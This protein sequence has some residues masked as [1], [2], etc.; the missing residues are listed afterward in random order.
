MLCKRPPAVHIVFNMVDRF[1]FNKNL[2][3]ELSILKYLKL[4]D[5]SIEDIFA[6]IL[7]KEVE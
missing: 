2:Y 5:F 4:T 7:Q 6:T 1:H 3:V